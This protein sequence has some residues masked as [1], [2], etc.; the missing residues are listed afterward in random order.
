MLT[1]RR[2]R[3]KLDY[4]R[5]AEQVSSAL[6]AT[7]KLQAESAILSYMAQKTEYSTGISGRYCRRKIY[8]YDNTCLSLCIK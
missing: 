6:L 1:G 2:I 8:I 5:F 4:A 7:L 3:N